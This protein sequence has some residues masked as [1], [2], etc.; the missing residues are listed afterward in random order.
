EDLLARIALT[1]HPLGSD[2]GNTIG[3]AGGAVERFVRRFMG[4]R[5]H[6]L[7]NSKPLLVRI[8]GL[9]HPQHDHAAA[10]PHRPARGIVDGAVPLRGVVNDDKAF[11][12]VTRF[13]SVSLTGH[14]CPGAAKPSYAATLPPPLGRGGV[15]FRP[16]RCGRMAGGSEEQGT[17]K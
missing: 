5:A 11:W 12:L 8:L 10:E 2:G 3:P 4:L 17:W 7:G 6:D 13:V 9:D 1:N 15:E 14:A 16:P